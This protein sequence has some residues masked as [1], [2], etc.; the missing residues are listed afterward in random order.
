MLKEYSKGAL[1]CKTA[2]TVQ[3]ST[4]KNNTI[5]GRTTQD[6]YLWH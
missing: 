4:R 1:V 2:I 5:Q 6:K 3:N